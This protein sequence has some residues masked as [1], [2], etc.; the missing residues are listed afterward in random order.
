MMPPDTAEPVTILDLRDSPW[1]DGPGR[2]I[3]E[4]AEGLN[5]AGFRYLIGAM[6]REGEANAYAD[7]ARRRGLE[8][9]TIVE[10]SALD[11]RVLQQV[12]DIIQRYRVS[13]VHAHEF[14]SD[15]IAL[16]CARRGLRHV[17]T[18]HGW[19]ANDIKGRIYRALDK[20]IVRG[21]D[22]VVVVSERIKRQLRQWGVPAGKLVV[23]PNALM[24]H[25]YRPNRADRV[26]RDELG[27]GAEEI[28]IANI[29]RLSAEKGQ[30]LFLRAASLLAAQH[31]SLRFLLIGI[32]P[33]EGPL[34]RLATELGI[35]DRV[36]FVGYRND[37]KRAYNSIDLVVQS[38]HTE[39]MPNVVLEALLMGVPVIATDVGGTGEIME[40]E[41]SGVLIPP[42]EVAAL[43][44]Q[45]QAF[46]AERARFAEM[47]R[48]GGER[49][50]RDFDS[51]KRIERMK[52]LYRQLLTE[53]T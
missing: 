7:E 21:F 43:A 25:E 16:L 27:I 50:R 11:R 35:D 5:R 36:M 34:R 22:R 23:V 20:L 29:G 31:R 19:I 30:D 17:T 4:I 33:E 37:M 13:I 24:I 6:V 2:T 3:L 41:R 52:R 49:V 42:G 44:T 46:L 45:M 51:L 18:V 12:A 47:A 32:G 40:H 26:L 1:V 10:R 9:V 48:A 8:V 14:R 53:A 28:V 38:S 39:G 15:A